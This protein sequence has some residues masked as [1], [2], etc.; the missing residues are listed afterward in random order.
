M[1]A[2]DVNPFR[3][4]SQAAAAA[5][6]VPPDL[7]TLTMSRI[8]YGGAML[9]AVTNASARGARA[10]VDQGAVSAVVRL[11]EWAADE[12]DSAEAADKP[13]PFM[14]VT[15]FGLLL[16]TLGACATP[17]AEAR[18]MLAAGGQHDWAAGLRCRLQ[19]VLP[20][21]TWQELQEPVAGVEAGIAGQLPT[22]APD[23]K[24]PLEA[25]EGRAALERLFTGVVSLVSLVNLNNI[26]IC[27]VAEYPTCL[28]CS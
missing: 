11:L 14:P 1:S 18:Q 24:G 6:G 20:P 15:T 3:Q 17:S 5:D 9:A 8:S 16:A 4:H 7:P 27:C 13:P 19:L 10:A 26:R 28:G 12:Y 21:P 22:E 23:E 25:V 2:C